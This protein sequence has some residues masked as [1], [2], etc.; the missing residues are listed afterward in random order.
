V[1]HRERRQD[2]IAE[3]AKGQTPKR[4]GAADA[5]AITKL[6]VAI[7]EDAEAGS[8]G[9]LRKHWSAARRTM[10]KCLRSLA[11]TGRVP[12]RYQQEL[13]S[14]YEAFAGVEPRVGWAHGRAVLR[15]PARFTDVE[16]ALAHVVLR[17]SQLGK[18]ALGYCGE[19]QTLW[20][21]RAG[22]RLTREFCTDRC[23]NRWNA[24]EQ[25]HGK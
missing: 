24:R 15:F 13:E 16:G 4:H 11:T 5:P 25:R 2:V 22:G 8:D 21:R 19:C 10:R 9:G 20:L 14:A 6:D 3:H 7:G 18:H 17:L 12:S 1:Q 23:R